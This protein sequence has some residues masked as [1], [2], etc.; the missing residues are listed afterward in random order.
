MPSSP[1]AAAY[2]GTAAPQ[3]PT[4]L[5]APSQSSTTQISTYLTT[6]FWADVHEQAARF[7]TKAGGGLNV[8]ISAL[9]AEG[10]TLAR[11]ALDAWS[12]VTGITFNFSAAP[13]APIHLAF[14]DNQAGAYAYSDKANGV[15]SK[16]Y[17]NVSTT[18]IANYGTGLASYSLQTY[19]HEIGH[20][21]G[22]GHAGD[23]NGS[24]SYPT[25]AAFADDSWQQSIMSYFSQNENT[26]SGASFAWVLSPQFAD[27]KAMEMLYG[28]NSKAFAG[29]TTFGV[30]STAGL[31]HMAIGDLMEQG[32]PADPISI[33]IFDRSGTD[34]MD[35]STDSAAQTID[36]TPGSASSI[37][38]LTG[39]LLIEAQ[40]I[41][42]N[43]RAGTG[44]D[45]LRGNLASNMIW[46]G[47]GDDTVEGGALHDTIYGEGG[48]DALL[49][50]VG[51]DS[52]LGGA[53]DDWLSGETGNDKLNGEAGSDTLLGGEGNDLAY[54]GDDADW[55]EGGVGNDSLYGDAAVD[56]LYGGRGNDKAYG[57]S[58]ADEIYGE[59]G[60]DSLYGGDGVDVMEGGEGND[61]VYGEAGA[62]TLYGGFGQDRVY[63]GDDADDLYG[64]EGNDLVYGDAGADTLRGEAGNDVLY[65]GS[66]ADALYGDIG[67]DSCFGGSGDDLLSDDAGN[68]SLRGE[69]G[70]DMLIGG[71]GRDSLDGG[72]GDDTLVA[73]S[74]TDQL[75]GGLGAD[76]FILLIGDAGRDMIKDFVSGT[77]K[78][79]LGDRLMGDGV[80]MIDGAAFS[81]QAGELRYT[82][83]RSGITVEFDNDGDGRSDLTFVLS[84]ARSVLSSDFL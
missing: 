13:G 24:A 78:I 66:E 2:A 70:N 60:N 6:G 8:D 79:G 30:G 67:N 65:G 10:Q 31:L 33:T 26:R 57:G 71:A 1:P 84:A 17:I 59:A 74:D 82:I 75:I 72:A 42:E 44:A 46:A 37:Y 76:V 3:Q 51:N 58:E 56:T 69:D 39:N 19:I 21:L 38:G 53:G 29:N 15:I 7:N 18:W 63:G 36:M 35:F 52:V 5:S 11:H 81:M 80:G 48:D 61:Y 20:A 40:T 43:L 47:A 23:Y 50:G 9:T 77:D 45:A 22:L 34:L 25:D 68:D 16:S 64:G 73:G 32:T 41:I 83:S 14:D 54:G 27:L 55:L 28:K 4:F 49:G 12:Q 62:E